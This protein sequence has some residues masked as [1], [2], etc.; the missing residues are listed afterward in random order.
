MDVATY[1]FPAIIGIG[2]TD[3]AMRPTHTKG[4]IQQKM[5]GKPKTHD[6]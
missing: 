2:L 5:V 6:G 3:T 1:V 4:N